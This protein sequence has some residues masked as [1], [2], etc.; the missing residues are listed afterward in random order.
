MRPNI[1]PGTLRCLLDYDPDTGSFVWNSRTPEMFKASFHTAKHNCAVWNAKHAG[2]SALRTLDG[3]GYFVGAIFDKQLLAHRVAWAVYYGMWPA[4]EI[5]HINGNR[6]DNRIKNL[7]SVTHQENGQNSSRPAHNTS[8]VTGVSWHKRD[9]VWRAFIKVDGQ[10][11]HIGSFGDFDSAVDA[12]KAAERDCEFH[13][14]H[15]KVIA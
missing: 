11:K 8:G 7:R 9:K 14:N 5:D 1:D 4:E 12:R 15:G 6:S 10:Y 2:K 13:P 3:N